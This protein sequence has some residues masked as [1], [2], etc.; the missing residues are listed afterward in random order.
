MNGELIHFL[1][2]LIVGGAWLAVLAFL[3]S[4]SPWLSI[5]AFFLSYA[6]P[7]TRKE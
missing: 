5:G 7:S 1:A 4:F 3:W 2:I 6:L